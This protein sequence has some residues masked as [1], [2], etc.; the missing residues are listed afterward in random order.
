M[1]MRTVAKSQDER[2][3]VQINGGDVGFATGCRGSVVKSLG[4][5]GFGWKRCG[6]GCA[7][8]CVGVGGVGR[9][10]VW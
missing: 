3:G 7:V 4:K 8:R 9:V 10:V 5:V 1:L 6:A 2:D